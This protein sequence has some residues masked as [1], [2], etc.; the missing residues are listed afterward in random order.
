MERQRLK[1]ALE[2]YT[3]IAVLLVAVAALCAFATSYLIKSPSPSLH[4]GLQRGKLLSQ[5]PKIDYHSSKR[6]LLIALNTKCHYCQESLPFY[7]TLVEAN[8]QSSKDLHIVAL[9]PDKAEEVAEFI[10]GNGLK[11]EVV[12][13]VQF[14]PLSISGTPS[15]ILVNNAGEID[16]FW[17]GK[18]GN[19]EAKHLMR[20]LTSETIY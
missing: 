15:I 4:V 17:V 5:I 19:T 13:E 9:F 18:L 3:N 1:S 10:R 6:T 8:S 7:R 16:D 11:I 20:S 2:T 12:P 14:A